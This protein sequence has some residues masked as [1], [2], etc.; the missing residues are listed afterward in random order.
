MCIFKII[1]RCK[2]DASSKQRRLARLF[3]KKILLN[4]S[5]FSSHE[6]N[7]FDLFLFLERDERIS[8]IDDL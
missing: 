5:T 6:L 2:D 4:V 7:Q 8:V 1:L 3:V